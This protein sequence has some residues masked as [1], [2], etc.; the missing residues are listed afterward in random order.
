MQPDALA[1][2]LFLSSS[3]T[4]VGPVRLTLEGSTDS[5]T[6]HAFD[7]CYLTLYLRVPC[8]SI[9]FDNRQCTLRASYGSCFVSVVESRD[10]A[11]YAVMT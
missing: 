9:L 11:V 1:S 4:S 7:L 2:T 10:S 6:K 8:L 5:R 3:G